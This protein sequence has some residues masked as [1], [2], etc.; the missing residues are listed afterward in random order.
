LPIAFIDID[1]RPRVAY[2]PEYV[3]LFGQQSFPIGT[4]TLDGLARAML[5]PAAGVGRVASDARR[6]TVAIVGGGASGTLLAARLLLGLTKATTPGR[7]VLI[8][9]RE[10]CGG[11]AYST[12]DTSHRLNVTASRMSAFPEDAGHFVRWRARS[13]GAELPG[14]YASRVEYGRY[15]ADVLVRAR[16]A[17]ADDAQLDRLAARV[18][19]LEPGPERVVLE[20]AGGDRVVADIAV[21][22]LGN[23]PATMPDAYRP[24]LGHPALVEDPWQPGALERVAREAHGTVLLIGTGLTMV[25]VALTVAARSPQARLVAASRHGLLPRPHLV[26]RVAAVPAPTR[27]DTNVS[28]IELVDRVLAESERGRSRWHHLVDG[29]RPLTQA[30]WQR[31][32]LEQ[33]K[34]FMA[35]RHRAWSVHRHRMAPEVATRLAALLAARRLEIRSGAPA[36]ATRDDGELVL[37]PERELVSL[38]VNCTGPGLDP[39]TCDEPLVRQLLEAGYVRAH[40]LGMGFDTDPYGAL[41]D[42]RGRPQP[43]LFTLGPPRIGDLY[44]TTAIPEIRDEARDLARRCVVALDESRETLTIRASGA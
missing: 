6:P 34:T 41:R 38:V 29:L 20:L 39:R 8:D 13:V 12:T 44:E 26:G 27:V 36:L 33:R 37:G 28:F 24:L 31:L 21:L 16:A 1:R 3:G 18:V 2:L 22:A 5:K 9:P 42:D 25:D 32:S 4:V 30:H 43:R 7:V 14:A 19:A 11:L 40:P 23:L 15:L 35:T 17:A 10:G